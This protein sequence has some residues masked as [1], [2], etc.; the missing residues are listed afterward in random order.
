[1]G[2]DHFITTA[3][4]AKKV[5]ISLITLIINTTGDRL[6][7]MNQPTLNDD[8]KNMINPFR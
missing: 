5:V 2:A 8:P 3:I 6:N 1:M 7:K 4:S